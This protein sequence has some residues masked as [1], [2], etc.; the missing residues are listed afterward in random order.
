MDVED[1][2]EAFS[3]FVFLLLI[4]SFKG[5]AIDVSR[6]FFLQI[7][8]VSVQDLQAI[9]DNTQISLGLSVWY[10][11]Y[12][13]VNSPAPCEEFSRLNFQALESGRG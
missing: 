10:F 7:V 12:P 13:V 6:L 2:L 8:N 5:V 9:L 1:A 11:T 4:T 3:L